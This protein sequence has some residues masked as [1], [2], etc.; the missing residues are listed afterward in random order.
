LF[1]IPAGQKVPLR[2]NPIL[3]GWAMLLLLSPFSTAVWGQAGPPFQTDDPTP[4]D[5][6]HYEAYVFGTV[7]GTPV[8][9]DTISPGFEFNWG[10]IPNIQLHVI[11]PLGEVIPSNKP[12]YAPGGMGPSAFGLQDM[13]L[14]VKW[15][16][17]KQT[18]RRPQIGSFTMFE[19]PTG[20]YSKGLGVGK[21]WYKLPIWVEKEFGPWSLVGGLGY[22]VVPQY[23]YKKYL[24]GGYLV[25]RT[26]IE[27]LELSAEV[28]SH[29]S[30]GFAAA[31]TQAST[32]ID[33]GGYYHFKQPGLQLLFAYGHSIAG[34]TENYAYL[35][36]YKTWG[37]GKDADK[38]D[39]ADPMRSAQPH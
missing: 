28:F 11:L 30:E 33:A 6:G 13:E 19:I 37:K 24:Y 23:Q 31:Q 14:G 35:G 22:A 26:L 16:F 21:V 12:A 36:L 39:T 34:Q 7:D 3:V 1:V 4:V 32:L 10:A 5:L 38:K 27:K 29:A 17:I 18:K 20:S 15:G 2:G 25:K 8:E 9:L